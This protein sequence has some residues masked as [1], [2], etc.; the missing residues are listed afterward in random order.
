[1]EHSSIPAA[2]LRRPRKTGF[3][4]RGWIALGAALAVVLSAAGGFIAYANTLPTAVTLNINDGAKDVPTDAQLAFRFT[5]PVALSTVQSALSVT[6]STDG[7]LTEVLGQ[8]EFEWVATK[9]L[10]ELTAYTVTIRAIKDLGNH[11]V[12]AS[13]WTFTTIIVP[14]VLS[15]SAPGGWALADGAEIDPATPLQINFNDAM[16]HATVSVSVGTKVV[17][18]KWAADDRSAG[19][20]TIGF[21]SGPVIVQLAPGARDQ[22]GHVIAAPV[23]LN[24][25]IY[26]HDRES[27]TALKFPALIQIPNDEFARDQNGLQAAGIIFEY[28]AEGGITRLTAIYQNVPSLV[29]PMRSSRFISLK[30]ARH[31]RGL[32]FQSGESQATRSRGYTDPVPQFF[33][34]VGYTFRTGVRYAPDNLM[35]TGPS[36]RGAESLFGISAFT[37]PKARPILTGGSAVT[38]IGIPEHYSIYS[39][40][41]VFGTYQKT[42]EGHLYRDA[43]THQLIRIEMLIILHTQVQLLDVGDGHGAHIHDYNLDSSGKMDIFYKGLRYAGTWTSTDAHGPLTFKLANGQALS[44]PPGLVWIDVTA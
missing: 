40:D 10:T 3:A 44:L 20:S 28:V 27:T 29:G 23:T 30:I 8:T 43:T 6:P 7:T 25:G 21:P 12:K 36:V 18:L 4:R 24:T 14:R 2:A 34:T 39:Y 31:Y 17:V 41:P 22:T 33:D 11:P 37:L 15:I 1:M 5:R 35:I 26:Y 19:I 13:Q 42:E 16:D 9:P 38:S 32:L